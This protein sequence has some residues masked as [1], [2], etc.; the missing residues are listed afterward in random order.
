[1]ENQKKSLYYLHYYADGIEITADLAKALVQFNQSRENNADRV[2]V[3]ICEQENPSLDGDV[4]IWDAIEGAVTTKSVI[5]NADFVF[6]RPS[7]PFD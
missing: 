2:P 3:L 1:M 5:D 6:R 4:F 7:S